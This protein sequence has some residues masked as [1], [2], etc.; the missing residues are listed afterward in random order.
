M[1]PQIAVCIV[2]SQAEQYHAD[3][4]VL[5]PM[6]CRPLHIDIEWPA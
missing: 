6:Q 3:N 1:L 5:V 4:V 2:C